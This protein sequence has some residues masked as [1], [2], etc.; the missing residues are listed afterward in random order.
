MLSMD[1]DFY[2]LIDEGVTVLNTVK[3]R[4]R[5][6]VDRAEVVERFGVEPWQWCDFWAL[7]GDPSDNIPGVRGIGQ[8]QPPGFWPRG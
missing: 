8:V 3:K 1:K 5:A 4:S 7:M 6:L 2:Q